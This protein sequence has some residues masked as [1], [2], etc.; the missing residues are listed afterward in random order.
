MGQGSSRAARIGVG[1]GLDGEEIQQRLVEMVS[2]EAQRE[3]LITHLPDEC[4]ELIFTKLGLLDRNRCAL[5]CKRWLWIEAEGRHLLSLLARAELVSVVPSL[6]C[7]FQNITKLALKCDRGTV[8]IDDNALFLI[9]KQCRKL[10]RLN[11]KGCRHVSD[12]G[13]KEFAKVCGPLKKLSCGSCGFGAVGLNAVLQHCSSLEDLSVKKLRGF[14]EDP[15][16]LVGPG[17]DK[18]RRLSLKELYNAHLFAPLMAGS[19]NLRTLILSRVSGN[20][21]RLLE[22]I[23]EHLQSLVELHIE[24]LQLGDRGLRAIGR[25][26]NLQVLYVVKVPH[27]TNMGV[28]AVANGCRLL[29]KL[30]LDGCLA[31]RIGD[32]GLVSIAE[33]CAE[34]QELVLMSLNITVESIVRIGANCSKLE[35]LA[36]CN[37]ETFGDME[38]S[39]IATKCQALKK[40]CIKCCPISDQGVEALSDG[41]PNLTKVKIK[42]CRGVSY[43]ATESLHIT[44]HKLAISFDRQLLTVADEVLTNSL[45]HSSV[46]QS[47]L[48]VAPP[49]RSALTKAKLALVAGGSFMACNFLR[50]SGLRVSI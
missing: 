19:K 47:A 18:I 22:A 33:K 24:K 9:G 16:E 5:V 46:F 43:T 27:C 20:W 31:G 17:T 42:K 25:C 3:D 28:S 2:A 4:L 44:R 14:F 12:E 50:R 29:R 49:S 36:L 8:S 10:E 45:E 38:L 40:L 48:A 7:R 6:F 32:E 1:R 15:R 11:L 35:R 30:H 23:S 37:C 13:L 39:S 26:K 21:D 34:L 41:C